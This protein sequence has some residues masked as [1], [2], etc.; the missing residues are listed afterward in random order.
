MWICGYMHAAAIPAPYS[1][2]ADTEGECGK[3]DFLLHSSLAYDRQL[4]FV[5]S[6]GPS[7]MSWWPRQ[8]R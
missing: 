1:V 8:G 2:Y 7:G 3:A 6:P 4:D 5:P